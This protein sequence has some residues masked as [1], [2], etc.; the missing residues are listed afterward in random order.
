MIPADTSEWQLHFLYDY[1]SYEALPDPAR[2]ATIPAGP[3]A[4]ATRWWHPVPQSC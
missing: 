1:H 3:A 2:E 4:R